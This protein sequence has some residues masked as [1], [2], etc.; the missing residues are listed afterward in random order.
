MTNL[1]LKVFRNAISG[2]RKEAKQI[3][4]HGPCQKEEFGIQH[5]LSSSIK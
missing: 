2:S 3:S 1:G 4:P 5:T